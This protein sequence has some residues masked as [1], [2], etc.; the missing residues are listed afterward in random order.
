MN[1]IEN[2]IIKLNQPKKTRG[3]MEKILPTKTANKIRSGVPITTPHCEWGVGVHQCPAPA[4]VKYTKDKEMYLCSV[5]AFEPEWGGLSPEDNSGDVTMLK[6]NNIPTD[7]TEY[8]T[9]WVKCP[10]GDKIHPTQDNVSI[11]TD[12]HQNHGYTVEDAVAKVEDEF[13]VS[14]IY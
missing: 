1:V 8:E 10:Q 9:Q 5:H 7:K 6:G 3:W 13:G 11:I 14:F 12:L 2:E 4:T